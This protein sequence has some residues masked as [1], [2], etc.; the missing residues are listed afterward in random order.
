[1]LNLS[2]YKGSRLIRLLIAIFF[3]FLLI[4]LSIGYF[5]SQTKEPLIEKRTET[6]VVA[7]TIEE[8][9]VITYIEPLLHQ[10]DD[11][12]FSLVGKNGDEIILLK[13]KDQKLEVSEGHFA[14]VIGQPKKTTKGED[15]ILVEKVIIKNATN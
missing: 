10:E 13:A 2:E 12:K 11:I 15:Y 8:E 6:R 1:M 3:V 14:T 4:G 5:I 9:G 7:T